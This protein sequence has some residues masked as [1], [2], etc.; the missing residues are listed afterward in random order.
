MS[1]LP[2]ARWYVVCT[3]AHGEMRA[4]AQ[5]RQ[6]GFDVYLPRYLKR[7]RHARR[8]ETIAAPLFPRYLFVSL[9]IA[10]QQWR[11]IRST[12]GV[13]HLICRGDEPVAISDAVVGEIRNREAPSGFVEI[14][15]SCRFSP[16][17]K[18]RVVEG[19]LSACLGL[20]EGTTDK[21]RVSVLLEMLGRQ[22]RVVLHSDALEAA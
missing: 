11:A 10:H 18:V 6:Q 16:G 22:V 15:P 8:V 7:R 9:D 5:L 20:F 3:Q 19:A 1:A 2:R 14:A 13:S 17:E 21:S 4:P 12:I